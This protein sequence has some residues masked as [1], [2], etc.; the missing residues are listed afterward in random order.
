MKSSRYFANCFLRFAS[1][2]NDQ[3]L[4][5]RKLNQNTIVRAI[6][7]DTMMDNSAISLKTKSSV[8][9]IAALLKPVIR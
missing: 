7:L 5:I 1:D 3:Y 6:E 2:L 9:S 4:F 8:S